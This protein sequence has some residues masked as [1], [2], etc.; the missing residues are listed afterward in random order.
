MVR[1]D[2]AEEIAEAVR[3]RYL[4]L[5]GLDLETDQIFAHLQRFIGVQGEPPRQAAA[6]AVMCY[7]FER[8]DIFEDLPLSEAT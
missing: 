7:F 2:V 8:C 3:E 5:K 6:L 1:P 4:S